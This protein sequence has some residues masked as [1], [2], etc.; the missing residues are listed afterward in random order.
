MSRFFWKYFP[1]F[2]VIPFFLAAFRVETVSQLGDL[3]RWAVLLVSFVAVVVFGRKRS[4]PGSAYL[5][6]GVII[7][8]LGLFLISAAWSINP[9]YT[10][11]RALSLVLLYVCAFWLL[12]RYADE[13]SEDTLIRYL[14]N[15]VAFILAVN[16]L[17]GAILFPDELF[18][19]R[20]QG[21]FSNPN[22]IGLITS[23]T[24]PLAIARWLHTHKKLDLLVTGILALNLMG[25]GSRAALL[26]VAIAMAPILISLMV[27]R[28]QWA[29]LFSV[30]AIIIVGLFVNTA[31]FDEYVLREDTLETASNR[32]FIWEIAED[33][34]DRRPDLGHGFASDRFIHDYY[35][36]DLR[37]LGLRGYGVMSSYYGL[38]VQ[39]GL[40][41]TVIFFS[42][43]WGSILLNIVRYW[44]DYVL[45][46]LF[47]TLISGLIVSVFE[48]T[49]YSA[50]N[51]FSFL[52]WVWLMLALRRIKYRRRYAMAARSQTF[53][54]QPVPGL[55]AQAA[56]RDARK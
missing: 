50:G 37:K 41:I 47:A 18:T 16:L 44:K 1:V 24:L 19:R 7:G 42:L 48:N 32:T 30:M 22:A 54:T 13:Y 23:V 33:Y 8:F 35:H 9:S 34:I 56:L 14:L 55:E 15:T 43:L 46:S 52:F 6:D 38:A 25:S 17:G 21:L 2:Y 45:V 36:V 27:K 40:P 5:T 29:V 53:P 3:L 28:P 39:M 51:M 11:L 49:L 10:V 20:F 12:W 4:K 31:Y 26:G